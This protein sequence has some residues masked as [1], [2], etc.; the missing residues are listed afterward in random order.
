MKNKLAYSFDDEPV[1]KFCCDLDNNKIEIYFKGYFDLIE[2][3][4]IEKSCVWSIEN[5]KEAKSRIGDDTKLY[6]LT[7]SVGIFSLILY[8]K[9]S[10]DDV[11]EML[12]NTV[13]NR[14]ITIFLKEPILKLL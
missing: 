8:M 9:Y 10:E 14:Y 1:S 2:D 6:D 5:W 11:L 4:Y 3:K 12:V 7:K 13:D